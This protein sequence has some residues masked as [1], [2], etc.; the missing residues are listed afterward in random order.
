[1]A[2]VTAS[3]NAVNPEFLRIVCDSCFKLTPDKDTT[4][5]TYAILHL[6]GKKQ[7]QTRAMHRGSPQYHPDITGQKTF[8]D[9][10]F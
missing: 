7:S 6:I 5:K 1:M 9:A 3:S 8:P 2:I 4:H 10:C